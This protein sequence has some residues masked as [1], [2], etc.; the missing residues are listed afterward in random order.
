MLRASEVLHSGKFRTVFLDRDGVLNEKLPEGC[1]VRTWDEFQVLPGVP[2]AIARLN[3][4]GLRVVVVSN[5]RGIALG[6]CTAAD[7]RT[8][9][10]EFEALLAGYGA[11]IDAFYIC[12]HDHGTCNCRKPLSG[13]FERAAADF[14]DIS[15][16]ASVMIGDSEADMEFGT[17]LGMETILIEGG[18][19]RRAPGFE[20]AQALASQRFSFLAEAVSALLGEGAGTRP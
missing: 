3:E 2:E 10:S 8:I 11:H 4:S 7:V 18:P 13:M 15:A 20:K 14:P 17:R 12:P 5:Q 9:H 6:L 1:Y 19:E 16:A